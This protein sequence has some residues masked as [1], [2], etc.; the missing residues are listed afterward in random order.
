MS[1]QAAPT[2]AIAF[3]LALRPEGPWSVAAIHPEK[4]GIPKS[5]TSMDIRE[6]HNWIE[7]HRDGWNL[8]F[9]DNPPKMQS[10]ANRFKKMSKED[11]AAAEF[12]K[13]DIDRDENGVRLI[14]VE[15]G[16]AAMIA[17]LKAGEVEPGVPTF[18]IDSG[19]G[20]QAL[21][22]YA[23]PIR[24]TD[25][26]P[27]RLARSLREAEG[28]SRTIS[29]SLGADSC[30]SVNHLFRLPGTMNY[31]DERKRSEGLEPV[32]TKLV[33]ADKARSYMTMDC[34]LDQQLAM[35][36][37]VGSLE[38]GP[39]ETLDIDTLVHRYQL[40]QS[41][42]Q[43]ILNAPEGNRSNADWNVCLALLE[44]GVQPEEVH[45]VL[46]NPDFGISER[47][48][49]DS[50]NGGDP[51][52]FS[53]KTVVR[54]VLKDRARRMA[55]FTSWEEGIADSEEGEVAR[56]AKSFRKWHRFS[57]Q[58][59]M[60]FP[61]P[62]W[63]VKGVIIEKGLSTIFGGPKVG[64][65]WMALH[66]AL[67]VA[68]GKDFFGIKVKKGRVLYV[69]GEGNPG[70]FRDRVR[71]WCVQHDYP[72][73]DLAGSFE[74]VRDPVMLDNKESYEGFLKVD[75]G[76]YDLVIFDTF[77][78]SMEG[79][80]NKT[81]DMNKAVGGAD[82]VRRITKA[83]VLFV[84]H[85]QKSGE[86][87]RGSSVMR[88]AVDSMFVL[89]HIDDKNKS[90]GI[91][92]STFVN[93]S[94]KDITPICARI[95][96]VFF[97]DRTDLPEDDR[98]HSMALIQIAEPVVN[99][100]TEGQKKGKDGK[101]AK[102]VTPEDLLVEIVTNGLVDIKDLVDEEIPGR[103][104]KSVQRHIAKL[105]ADGYLTRPHGNKGPKAGEIALTERGE[106]YGN[107]L[108]FVDP[109]DMPEDKDE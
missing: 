29:A 84:H 35:S 18:I 96:P 38:I 30:W 82:A 36:I 58:D 99:P 49:D 72:Y 3:L 47:T 17:R 61:D 106:A 74:V 14:N 88:G 79:D 23:D 104:R 6:I 80:E 70:E 9:Q 28:I 1:A 67:C 25:D 13:A 62:Q 4:K 101:F 108:S 71:A 93:R 43:R 109:E 27:E 95:V 60:S 66:L 8:Y 31:P 85:S 105:V 40:P 78:R 90:A 97:D 103:S 15:G 63:L 76:P 20:L 94:A 75:R 33:H 37:P 42:V 81:Q 52:A 12:A 10:H 55:E 16:K 98:D 53:R 56:L 83:A 7:H 54:A 11:T 89:K 64:K 2:E 68:T 34:P 41:L 50:K 92:F 51:E 91:R 57:P 26:D 107:E 102:E 46:L 48:L 86:L 59:L 65:T 32:P 44:A 24:L 21:W 100:Q 5:L 73:E 87:E 19:N 45:G 77:A 22:R 39:P 69:I